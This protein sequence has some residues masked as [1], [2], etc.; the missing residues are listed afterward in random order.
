LKVCVTGVAG[1]IGSNIA[2]K[3]L[4]KG[5]EVIG[6]DCFTDYYDL[7]FKKSH[8]APIIGHEKFQFF[9][10]DIMDFD[11]KS[12]LNKGDSIIHE[13]AQAG[14]RASWG[15]EFEI[16]TRNN[17]HSTQFV[18]EQTK[19]IG[20]KKF[21]FAGSSSVYGDVKTFPMNE[22]DKPRP[23]SPYGVSKLAAEH[24][25]MLYHKNFNVPGISLRYFTVFGPGQR[26]DMAFHRFCKALITDTEMPVYGNGEQTR[27]FTFIDDIANGTIAAMESDISGEVI[28]LGGGSRISLGE[29]IEILESI[30]GKEAK[31]DR[32]GFQ[33]GDVHHTAA[34][35]SKAQKLLG[36]NPKIT[37]AEGLK[38]EYRWM[39]SI[40]EKNHAH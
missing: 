36:F 26:P 35:I 21:V 11:F 31:I 10:T 37:V 18:L 22:E 32:G 27:D 13:A 4:A 16:Y 3:L 39:E 1:F 8:L 34:D 38:A 33:K 24:L 5:I 20:L 30:A 6:V 14:V 28:N 9:Q 23:V 15:K 25:V 17:I 19:D 12:A 29:C 40:L 7:A 2:E